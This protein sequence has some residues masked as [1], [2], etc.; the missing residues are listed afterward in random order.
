MILVTA[1]STLLICVW[2][3]KRKNSDSG[4]YELLDS[5]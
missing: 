1:N 2:D 5:Y 3:L 4:Q